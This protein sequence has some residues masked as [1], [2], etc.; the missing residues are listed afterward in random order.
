MRCQ[1]TLAGECSCPGQSVQLAMGLQGRE[2]HAAEGF[3]SFCLCSSRVGVANSLAG[4]PA[5]VHA[6]DLSYM[7]MISKRCSSHASSPATASEWARV[8]W[9]SRMLLPSGCSGTTLKCQ[10]LRE[11]SLA[12]FQ[13]CCFWRSWCLVYS[14]I[15][16]Y[17][18]LWLELRIYMY[19]WNK[20]FQ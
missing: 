3:F 18:C 7:L 11:L 14:V 10:M 8:A 17:F 15:Y 16:K 13:D 6:K 5:L 2:D 1:K 20:G 12:W 19:M 4:S 9:R